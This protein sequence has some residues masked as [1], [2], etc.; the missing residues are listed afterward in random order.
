MVE[1]N[2]LIRENKT[3]IKN[4][5]IFYQTQLQKYLTKSQLITLKLLVWLLQSHKQVK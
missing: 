2:G 3:A 1:K 5:T 4:A